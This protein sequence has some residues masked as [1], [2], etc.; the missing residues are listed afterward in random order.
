[1]R[2]RLLPSTDRGLQKFARHTSGATER[3]QSQLAMPARKAL[4]IPA[5]RPIRALATLQS[6]R[7]TTATSGTSITDL[8]Q[9]MG[10]RAKDALLALKDCLGNWRSPSQTVTHLNL[11]NP[12]V[13]DSFK[14]ANRFA[15]SRN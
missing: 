15:V 5:T 2:G 11:Q 14:K 4:S 7:L 1:M 13:N 10:F 9:L 8:G 12:T 6:Y 3:P